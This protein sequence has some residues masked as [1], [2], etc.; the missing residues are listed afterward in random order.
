MNDTIMRYVRDKKNKKVGIL[1]AQYG[2]NRVVT[3]CW[4]LC[5]HG[6]AFSKEDGMRFAMDNYDRPVPPSLRHA[7]KKFRVQCFLY[8]KDA[9]LIDDPSV[10]DYARQPRK[11]RDGVTRNSGHRK[12]CNYRFHMLG[13]EY[14]CICDELARA[15]K[16]VAPR[17]STMVY[18]NDAWAPSL[19]QAAEATIGQ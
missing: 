4:S 1:V 9:K 6:D 17:G 15:D 16:Q 3:I 2:A 5:R 7:L 12:G 19:T 11:K 18:A 14:T 8:F 10:M 13:A